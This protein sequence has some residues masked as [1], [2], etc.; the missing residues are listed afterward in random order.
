M[1]KWYVCSVCSSIVARQE[2]HYPLNMSC[3]NTQQRQMA[4]S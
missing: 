1:F 3:Y 4:F 2:L